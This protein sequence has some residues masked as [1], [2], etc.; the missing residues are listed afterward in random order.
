MPNPE[1]E[2]PDMHPKRLANPNAKRPIHS[3]KDYNRL[4]KAA[5]A[6]GWWCV[7]ASNNY[8]KCYRPSDNLL[9][10][11]PS[12]PRKQGTLNLYT[13]KLRKAGVNL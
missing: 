10:P 7:R 1:D 5:W 6:A 9:I 13:D 4:V 3:K 11:L 2:P 8:I 12:T